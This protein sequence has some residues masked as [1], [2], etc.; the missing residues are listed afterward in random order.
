VITVHAGHDVV[1]TGFT[2]VADCSAD[3][4]FLDLPAPYSVIDE[5]ARVLRPDGAI[6]SFSPCIEQVQRTCGALRAGPFH[7]IRT[8]TAPTRTYE[9]R[10]VVHS[11]PGFDEMV[12]ASNGKK[13][14]VDNEATSGSKRRRPS[15]GTA[16]RERS[17][18][19]DSHGEN[20]LAGRV[21][22]P[23][24]AIRSRPFADMK[25]HTSYLSFARRS[26][27]PPG[28]ASATVVSTYPVAIGADDGAMDAATE[29]VV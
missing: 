28:A 11:A 7:S 26:R 10:A 19:Y 27:T 22:R 18:V 8:I 23:T 14:P 3:A 6:C 21:L 9:S 5:A 16:A 15:N 2:G 17:T 13:L 12:A 20:G 1:A 25:S 24:V 29:Y 4:V